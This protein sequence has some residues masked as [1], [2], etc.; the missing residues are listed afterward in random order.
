MVLAGKEKRHTGI[1][2]MCLFYFMLV[3]EIT[4]AALP[5]FPEFP[6]EVYPRSMLTDDGFPIS[7]LQYPAQGLPVAVSDQDMSDPF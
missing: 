2:L 7:T 6:C 4:S 1:F 5:S 3:R